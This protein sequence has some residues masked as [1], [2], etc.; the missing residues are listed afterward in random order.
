MPIAFLCLRALAQEPVCAVRGTVTDSV[1]NDPVPKAQVFATGT[2]YSVWR[3]TDPSGAF[4]FRQLDSGTYRILVQ[5]PGY[6][7]S[8]NRVTVDTARQS[9]LPPLSIDID[10]QAVIAGTVLDSDGE[11]LAGAEVAM[12]TRKRSAKGF[13][14]DEAEN[15]L[16]GPGGAFRFSALSE[17]TY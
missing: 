6:L 15:T 14:P 5:K 12:W 16:A 17:G 8:G 7:D 2:H 3:T 4:C 11:P 10:P 13:E 9:A 1:T